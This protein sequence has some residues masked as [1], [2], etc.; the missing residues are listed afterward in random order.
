MPSSVKD[1]WM[2]SR[3]MEGLA[4]AGGVKDVTR[5]LLAAIA[6]RG[7]RA[8]LVMPLYSLVDRQP[9]T[10]TGIE[11]AFPMNL[12][13]EE[14][15]IHARIYRTEQV[16]ASIFLV[17]TPCYAEKEG[18]YTYTRNEAERAGESELT[19]DGYLDYF[20]MNV[21]LQKAI[22][23]LAQSLD[24]R[25][26][27]IHCQDAHTALI[28][29]MMR[30]VPR[31]QAYFSG[32]GAGITVHNAGPGYHQEVYDAE[33]AQAITELPKGVLDQ[34]WHRGGIYPFIVGGLY[35]DF[36]NT[37]SEN[38]AREVVE[39]PAEDEQTVGI[40]SAFLERGIKLLGVTNGIDPAEYNPTNPTAMGIAAGYDPLSGDMAGKR[41]C[42]RAL[43]AEINQRQSAGVQME[44]RL[45]DAPGRPLVTMI[46]RLTAQKGV[47]RFI[48]AVRQLLAG[49]PNQ[50][51]PDPDVLFLVL[52]T[53]DPRYQE[54]LV[55]LARD[56]RFDGRIAVA[57]GYGPTLAQR[58]YAGG[59]FFVNPA[60]FEP[61]GLTDYIAQL[62]G[63][64]PIVH[65]VG[66]LVKVEDGVT[67]YGYA[68][69]TPE[70]LAD[71]LRRAMIT[72]RQHPEQHQRIIQQAIRRIHDRYTW[73]KVLQRGYLPLYEGAVREKPGV[74]SRE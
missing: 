4:G 24:A 10:D 63:N 43:I 33:F 15:I 46:S 48:D 27:L 39:A 59:D 36:I 67:G 31:Y 65:L 64:V 1:V 14:R 60:A 73:D 16:G 70:A 28:P 37:V 7:I 68:P 11:L 12:T 22:L 26:D 62:M 42:R 52:G 35:A 18:I 38:Y 34:G 25:P 29:A 71:T 13:Y 47:D 49:I 6:H 19:G 9:L 40:G 2:V 44:G 23:E 56:P 30:T 32:I 69:H 45:D 51:P 57:A 55:R 41:G 5:Q 21:V 17:D 54:A 74:G 61:C 53:G 72:F 20:Q 8:T 3:E 66:G 50:S 58:I